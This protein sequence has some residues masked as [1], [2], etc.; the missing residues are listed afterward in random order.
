MNNPFETISNRLLHVEGLLLE[1]KSSVS[2][3]EQKSEE[4]LT[5]KQ[6]AEFLNVTLVTLHE[7]TKLGLVK[8]GRIGRRVYYK[9]SELLAATSIEKP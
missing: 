6:A 1:L 2:K 3:T 8:S 5:R 7:W 9:K 4:L